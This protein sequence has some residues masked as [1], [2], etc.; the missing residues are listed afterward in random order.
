VENLEIG[1]KEGLIPNFNLI[2]TTNRREES[3]G[4]TE[5]WMLLQ[6]IDD[7]K[8][9]V[10]RSGIY[11]FIAARTNL[12]PVEAI[13]K[14]RAELGRRPEA[15][16]HLLR[17]IPVEI[18]VPSEIERMKEAVLSLSGRI[19]EEESF[20]ITVEKRRT[21]LRSREII[22]AVAEGITRKVDLENPAWVIL[23]EVVGKYTGISVL[24]PSEI[25]NTVKERSATDE[26]PRG[27]NAPRGEE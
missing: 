5:L 12:N 20:R 21:P 23:I 16:K 3:W 8:P 11:G 1:D 9:I 19:G 17:L 7:P 13:N 27:R 6:D 22:E 2:A 26:P 15:F 18:V 25:L 10:D 4:C 24:K 14:L